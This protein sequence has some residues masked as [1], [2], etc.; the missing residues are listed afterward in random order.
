[1]GSRFL[2]AV[3][4]EGIFAE[5]FLRRPR[6][7]CFAARETLLKSV[8]FVPRRMVRRDVIVLSLEWMRRTVAERPFTETEDF[9]TDEGSSSSVVV[10]VDLSSTNDLSKN[11]RNTK[12]RS[13]TN[14][15]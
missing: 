7:Y 9:L 2:E 4:L 12:E 1:M 15:I 8:G 11:K 3:L 10:V 14:V 6:K 5:V 13:Q